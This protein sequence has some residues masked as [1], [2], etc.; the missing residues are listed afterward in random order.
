MAQNHVLLVEDEEDLRLIVGD[1]LSFC[2][3]AVTTARDGVEALARL[4][5]PNEFS[6]LVTDVSMPEGVSGL[7]VADA[8][9]QRQP[10]LRVIVVSGYQRSQL[11]PIPDSVVF[12]PKPYR[13]HQLLAALEA[14]KA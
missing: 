3:F 9:L 8:A 6:H 7:D 14:P 2:G 11:P 4:R 5:E 10:E 12:L 1:A 13:M